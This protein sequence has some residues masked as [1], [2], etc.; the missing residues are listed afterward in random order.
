MDA[1]WPSLDRPPEIAAGELHV[2]RARTDELAP[3]VEQLRSELPPDELERS[4]RFR[5]PADQA[6][7]IVARAL[8]RRLIRHYLGW[9]ESPFEFSVGP[10]GKLHLPAPEPLKFN[11][12]HSGHMV[13]VAI[14]RDAD[15]GVDVEHLRSL[16][17]FQELAE[18]YYCPQE[19]ATLNTLPAELKQRAFFLAWTRKEALLKGV[20]KGLTFP[21]CD[22]EVTLTP[23]EPARLLQFG[24]VAGDAA[25]WRLVHLEP[26]EEYVGAVAVAHEVSALRLFHWSCP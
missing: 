21:L 20:G 10:I 17:K 25:P 1:V 8:T 12:T 15:V 23:G 13:L 4:H 6:R 22:V 24:D 9:G 26:G 5:I 19:I 7:F 11:A 14:S 3:R 16:P 2:W 18:R